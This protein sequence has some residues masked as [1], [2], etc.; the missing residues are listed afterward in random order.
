MSSA[1]CFNLDQSTILSSGN[2]LSHVTVAP[3][4]STGHENSSRWFVR[5]ISPMIDDVGTTGFIA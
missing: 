1:I 2:G 4:V 5:P 3:L